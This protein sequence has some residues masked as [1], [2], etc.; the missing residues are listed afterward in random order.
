MH[1][2]I[3]AKNIIKE[4][5]GFQFLSCAKLAN[6]RRSIPNDKIKNI[7]LFFLKVLPKQIAP[8]PQ[9]RDAIKNVFSKASDSIKPRLTKGVKVIING[10]IIQCTAQM[11]LAANPNLSKLIF[12]CEKI[13]HINLLTLIESRNFVAFSMYPI[14]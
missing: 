14:N 11:E 6:Q 8:T 3:S 2:K 9:I 10:T 12:I 7:N 5:C 1:I 4:D 13:L